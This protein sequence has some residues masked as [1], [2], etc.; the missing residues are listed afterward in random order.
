[1]PLPV[2]QSA[3]DPASKPGPKSDPKSSRRSTSLTLDRALL[4]E[5]RALKVNVSRA[6]ETGLASAVRAARAKAWQE[7]NADAI[8]SSNAYVETHGLPLAKY[9]KF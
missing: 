3:P 2:R 6:A 4:D 1:M 7:E 8:A 9:R 5:A